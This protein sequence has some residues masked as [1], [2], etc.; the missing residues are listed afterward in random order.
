MIAAALI[1]KTKTSKKTSNNPGKLALSGLFFVRILY[2]FPAGL[3][4][5]KNGF[6]S[7]NVYTGKQNRGGDILTNME[8][9][10]MDELRANPNNPRIMKTQEFKTLK[11]SLATLGDLSGIVFN[12]RS[13]QLVG[14]HQR[15]QAFQT[16]SGNKRVVISQRYDVPNRQGT[17]AIGYV[18]LDGE[19]YGY[20]EVDWDEGTEKAANT[21][22]NHISGE[23]DFD[24][25]AQQT[26]EISQLENGDELLSITG[27]DEKQI[28][29]L[30]QS[31]G[32]GPEPE[33]PPENL[34]DIKSEDKDKL[35]FAITTDQKAIINRA[36]DLVKRTREMQHTDAD[37]LNGSALFIL[38]S[39]YLAT[40]PD[41]TPVGELTDIPTA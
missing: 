35:V 1:E 24:L 6:T 8:T 2:H 28:N 12:V 36:L 41:T 26:Y 32:V 37:S 30:M 17:I 29:K 40:H 3:S 39:D 20:R 25:L 38:A 5:L 16:M 7:V 23:D 27:L 13:Q 33:L 15:I 9:K 19:M 14:G 21:A 31:V 18:E 34:D 22:A 10:N 11:K 4:N